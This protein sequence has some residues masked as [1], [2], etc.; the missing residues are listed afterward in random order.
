MTWEKGE[1]RALHTAEEKKE[2]KRAHTALCCFFIYTRAKPPWRCHGRACTGPA[3]GRCRCIWGGSCRL[4][5]PSHALSSQTPW[6]VWLWLPLSCCFV[7]SRL[8]VCRTFCLAGGGQ[9]LVDGWLEAAHMLHSGTVCLHGL[10]VLVQ[11]G[12]YLIVQDLVLPD[13]VCHFLQGLKG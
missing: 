6:Q 7:S 12:K 11:D 9:G 4:P 5:G 3:L 2:E 1:T 13:P 10:H 8:R